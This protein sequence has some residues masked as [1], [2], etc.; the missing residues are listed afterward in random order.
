MYVW[1]SFPWQAEGFQTYIHAREPLERL[2]DTV[3]PLTVYVCLIYVCMFEAYIHAW[4]LQTYIHTC[5]DVSD[6]HT[7][8]LGGPCLNKLPEAQ[9]IKFRAGSPECF[10][11]LTETKVWT[12]FLVQAGY[13]S[14]GLQKLR[15]RRAFSRCWVCMYVFG[16]T[17]LMRRAKTGYVCMYT[18]I[19]IV[20]RTVSFWK[21]EKSLG[22]AAAR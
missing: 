5:L 9:K 2:S 14:F 19:N 17:M 16:F 10:K 12:Y 11:T 15:W 13:L 6:I 20:S 21:F 8:T 22:L 7:Y 18:S 1:S 3:N 4:G